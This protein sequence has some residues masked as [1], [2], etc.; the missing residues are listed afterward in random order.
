[1]RGRDLVVIE[2]EKISKNLINLNVKFAE[3][4]LKMKIIWKI[5]TKDVIFLKELTYI[6]VTTA[7]RNWKTEI[8]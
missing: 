1:M 4:S 3:E 8:Y 5:M 6:N 7:V 2:K